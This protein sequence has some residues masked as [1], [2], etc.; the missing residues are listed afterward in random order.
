MGRVSFSLHFG[1]VFS[2]RD[3][4]HREARETE[5]ESLSVAQCASQPPNA[6]TPKKHLNSS[7]SPEGLGLRRPSAEGAPLSC[8]S[9]F[10]K[11]SWEGTD[12]KSWGWAYSWRDL[13]STGE[14]E[15]SDPE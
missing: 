2:P 5:K 10:H 13:V 14:Y 4:K 3:G 6:P 15:D 9:S 12:P 11:G 1:T 8:E 7:F